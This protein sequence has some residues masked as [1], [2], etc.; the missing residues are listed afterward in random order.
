MRDAALKRAILN[1]LALNPRLADLKALRDCDA[2]KTKKL[3]LWLDHSGL[4]LYFLHR[5]QSLNAINRVPE[6]F[7]QALESRAPK[8]RLRAQNML[9]EFE[10]L[11][12]SFVRHGA[13]Y[14]A[15]KGFTL[16]PD[17]CPDPFLRHQTDFDFWIEPASVPKAAV[18]LEECGYKLEESA[19]GE[20][21]F[22]TPL[23][24]IPSHRDD[25]YDAPRHRQVDLHTVLWHDKDCVPLSAPADCFHWMERRTVQG[26]SFPSLAPDDMFL[27]QVVHAFQHL[28]GSWV[29]LSWLYELDFFLGNHEH[30]TDFWEA[31]SLRTGFD[32]QLRNALGLILR[33]T[34][35]LFSRPLPSVL[36]K[37]CVAPLP[38]EMEAWVERF[39]A[40]WALSDFPGQKLTLFVHKSFFNDAK[41]WQKYLLGRIFPLHFRSSIM[42]LA[43]FTCKVKTKAVA[44]RYVRVF[45]RAA[46][47]VCEAGSLAVNAVRWRRALRARG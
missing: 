8:N 42:E 21:T 10:R 11:N 27:L 14:C 22:A 28:L 2:T 16:V 23:S 24:H 29:R 30:D 32:P 35:L 38:R 13:K 19:D 3:L 9:C 12:H 45:G 1:T 15:I 5:L 4:A 43:N 18:A 25:I 44:S 7:Y 36:E 33:L 39:G 47:H 26:V 37:W 20:M 6:Y 46:F 34:S 41:S 17:F 31:V 40:E